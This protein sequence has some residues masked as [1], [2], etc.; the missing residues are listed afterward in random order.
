MDAENSISQSPTPCCQGAPAVLPQVQAC[1]A[2]LAPICRALG[3]ATRLQIVALLA[4]AGR[5]LCACE[6]EAHFA[7]A[8]PTISHHLQVLRKAGLVETERRGT[9]IHYRLRPEAAQAMRAL[10]VLVCGAQDQ[11]DIP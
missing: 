11:G 8:Q 6:I 4:R 2:D 1:A 9:W 3:D 5:Y 10:A 7:L